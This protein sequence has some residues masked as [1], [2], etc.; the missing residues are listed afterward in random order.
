MKA[1]E[2]LEL[3][4]NSS[5]SLTARAAGLSVA[6]SGRAI[7]H[8]SVS[9]QART[10]VEPLSA[11]DGVRSASSTSTVLSSPQQ[12]LR[13]ATSSRLERPRS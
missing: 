10:L 6:L 7:L 8:L 1:H 5:L 4:N 12:S 2:Q 11:L 9:C 13:R 3:A